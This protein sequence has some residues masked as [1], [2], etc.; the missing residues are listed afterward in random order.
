MSSALTGP[1]PADT[2]RAGAWQATHIFYAANPRPMLTHCIRPLIAALEADGLLAGYFFINYWLEG[3]H[4]RLRIRPSCPE[5]EA[6]VRRR[7]EE[8]LDA[9]LTERPALYEVDSGF[10][11]EFYN[12]LF[13]IEFPGAERGAYMDDRGRMNLRPNNSRS[14]ERYEPEYAKYGGPAGIELA[15]W[16]FRH[17]SDLVIDAFRSKNL[18]LRTVL[19]G[20]SAQLMMVMSATFLPDRQKLADYLDSYYEFWH[21]AFPGTGFIGSDEYDSNYASMAAGLASRF[22][23][24]RAATA[25]E[26]GA[27]RLPG[28]LAG[29]A[30]HCAELR[31]RVV[32]LARDGDL[33]FPSRDGEGD[34]DGEERVT[35][36]SAALPMLLSPYMHMTNN[37]LHV[38][39]RDEAYLSHVL[40][41]A[42]RE[43]G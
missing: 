6:E 19:L 40:G 30:E 35:A 16:H 18:H 26:G 9:F 41:R 17:S 22:D 37:R 21:R 1:A 12:A 43:S 39:I 32:A 29:W 24:V 27:A 3:P 34:G 15:E 13:D 8:A 31:E 20:T 28:F 5:A 42:L 25:G 23:R 36:P 2:R 33:V 11:N 4:V 38:T 7:T 14:D 10:L